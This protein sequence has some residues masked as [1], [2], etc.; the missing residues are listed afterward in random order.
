MQKRHIEHAAFN[1]FWEVNP[2]NWRET[3]PSLERIKVADKEI[4]YLQGDQCTDVF[5]IAKGV[6]KLSCVSLQGDELTIVLLKDGEIFG[7]LQPDC[8]IYQM[9]ETA[10]AVGEVLVYRITL[11]EFK[12]LLFHYPALAWRVIEALCDRKQRAERK[13]QSILT[14]TVETRVV[15]TLRELAN[16]FGIRCVHGYAL[17]IRLT[18]QDI[19]D[20]VGASRPVVSTVLNGLRN[21]G[22]LDYTR[23]LICVNDATLTDY[24]AT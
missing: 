7:C 4:I 16:M 20:L 2:E 6:V 19:A 22:L 24:Y 3:C 23:E 11:D 5:G 13:L 15:N 17:E 18:Q 14:Q 9:E 21:R 1:L 10:Q 8:V 12:A